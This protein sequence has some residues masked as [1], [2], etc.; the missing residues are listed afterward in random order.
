MVIANAKRNG[1]MST[2]IITVVMSAAQ[3]V[4]KHGVIRRARA[5]ANSTERVRI[6]SRSWK[7]KIKDL[8]KKV[9]GGKILKLQKAVDA[10][11]AK[12]SLV[13]SGSDKALKV[14]DTDNANLNGV[15]SVDVK[16]GGLN[17]K[18]KKLVADGVTE[19]QYI[20]EIKGKEKFFKEEELRYDNPTGMIQAVYDCSKKGSAKKICSMQK[21]SV[22]DPVNLKVFVYQSDF[23]C[24]KYPGGSKG[25]SFTNCQELKKGCKQD[26]TVSREF[27]VTIKGFGYDVAEIKKGRRKL[28]MQRFR[29]GG[30][31]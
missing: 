11:I 15:N 31:S 2:S 3:G 12:S 20:F 24:C 23:L 21:K 27:S 9:P 29:G 30:G 4:E 16:V 8:E 13:K 14:T 5:R 1:G 28:L 25:T 7:K 26:L 22:K 18:T 19:V 6:V 10:P 17:G